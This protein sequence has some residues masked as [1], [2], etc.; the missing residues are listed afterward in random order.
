M[1][2]LNVTVDVSMCK[3]MNT[4]AVNMADRSL[5]NR[6]ESHASEASQPLMFCFD[7]ISSGKSCFVVDL[8][9]FVSPS[10][11]VF[12]FVNATRTERNLP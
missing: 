7:S 3:N 6:D 1:N 12:M 9:Y 4:P 10:I 2:E 8:V 5:I 11:K